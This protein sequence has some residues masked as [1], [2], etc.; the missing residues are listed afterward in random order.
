MKFMSYRQGFLLPGL[1]ADAK[2]PLQYAGYLLNWYMI[3]YE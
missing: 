2:S 1:F 3:A